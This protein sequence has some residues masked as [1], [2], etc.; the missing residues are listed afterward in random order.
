MQDEFQ[1]IAAR[2]QRALLESNSKNEK[3]LTLVMASADEIALHNQWARLAPIRN[4]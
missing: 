3:R 4:L 1:T 2:R